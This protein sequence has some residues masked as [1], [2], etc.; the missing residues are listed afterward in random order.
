M[1]TTVTAVGWAAESGQIR[2]K[3]VEDF[4]VSVTGEVMIS[5]LLDAEEQA[6]IEAFRQNQRKIQPSPEYKA[7]VYEREH[8]GH[9]WFHEHP[10]CDFSPVR[11]ERKPCQQASSQKQAVQS[12]SAKSFG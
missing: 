11:T 6:L 12:L 5:M 4:A 1:F 8:L 10:T 9:N 7:A 3:S 2:S